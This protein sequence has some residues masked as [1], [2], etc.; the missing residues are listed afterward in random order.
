M[1]S[2]SNSG[3]LYS[4]TI[5]FFCSMIVEKQI[6]LGV[7]HINEHFKKLGMKMHVG[8]VGGANKSKTEAMYIPGR[9]RSYQDGASL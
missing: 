8:V 4:L 9:S 2:L 7:A 1:G 5:L 6:Q 3:Y